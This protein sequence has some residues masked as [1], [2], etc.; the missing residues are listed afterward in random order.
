MSGT[1]VPVEEIARLAGHTS[2]RTTEIVYRHQLRPVVER[3]AQAMDQ[4][5]PRTASPAA[6]VICLP[7]RIGCRR[8]RPLC[9]NNRWRSIIIVVFAYQVSDESW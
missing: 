6:I 7:I 4:L 9:G 3:G 1:G 8:A 5:F 2:T